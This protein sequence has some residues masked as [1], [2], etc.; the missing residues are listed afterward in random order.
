MSFSAAPSTPVRDNTHQ[1]QP[2]NLRWWT[3]PQ[4]IAIVAL[5]IAVVA[6]AVSALGWFRPSWSHSF[7]SEETAH[8]KKN[9]CAAW[10]PVRKSVWEVTPNPRPGDP[11]ALDAVAANVRLAMLGGGLFLKETVSNETA[12]PA[13]LANA[14]K[15]VAA[16]LE[17]MG[18]YYVARM[19]TPAVIDPLKQKLDAQGA[20]V[21]RLCR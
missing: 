11:V 7:T 18:V 4:A 14:V 9:V 10:V 20:T 3:S 5:A 12:A 2:S 17:S 1:R 13:D 21:D 16:T 8:A 19:G 6:V 15:D